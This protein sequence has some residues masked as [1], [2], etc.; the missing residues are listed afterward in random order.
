M[1]H[2]EQQQHNQGAQ[3]QGD[4]NI[5]ANDGFGAQQDG[6]Q[7][8]RDRRGEVP[9]PDGDQ[10]G[11]QQQAAGPQLQA[12]NLPQPGLLQQDGGF[13]GVIGG[14]PGSP[15]PH[16]ELGGC[17]NAMSIPKLPNLSGLDPKNI[18]VF[19][20][21]YEIHLTRI[22]QRVESTGERIVCPPMH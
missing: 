20:R 4:G 15:R 10:P 21:D 2:Q 14:F 18:S 7:Q 3:E 13:G 17:V 6:A 8:D 1:E 16:Y 12:G 22:K 5:F 9:P 19:L 11:E